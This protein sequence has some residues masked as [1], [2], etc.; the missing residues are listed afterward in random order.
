MITPRQE[1]LIRENYTKI[2][3]YLIT[4][5]Y[6]A[7]KEGANNIINGMSEEWFNLIIDE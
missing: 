7:D 1:K 3:D 4:E 2:V 6:A 5:G